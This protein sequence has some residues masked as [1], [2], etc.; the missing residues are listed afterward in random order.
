MRWQWLVGVAVLVAGCLNG[1][2]SIDVVQDGGFRVGQA[3]SQNQPAPVLS[4]DYGKAF[5]ID[6][7]Y[8][9]Q[10]LAVGQVTQ[11]R[12]VVGYKAGLTTAA[13]RQQLGATEPVAGVLLPGSE[14]VVEL[15]AQRQILRIQGVDAGDARD[16]SCPL[17]SHIGRRNVGVFG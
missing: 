8:G 5:T 9:I 10:R 1:C 15:A 11:G 16:Q 2:N 17:V 14:I 12:R 7:A 4:P 13:A 3:L 6:K